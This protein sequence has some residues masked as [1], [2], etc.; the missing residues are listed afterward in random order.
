MRPIY[1]AENTAPLGS[2]RSKVKFQ[3]Y[4]VGACSPASNED[5]N[6]LSECRVAIQR[7][8]LQ[9]ELQGAGH[10]TTSGPNQRSYVLAKSGE[11]RS[12]RLA[13]GKRA[14]EGV[15]MVGEIRSETQRVVQVPIHGEGLPVVVVRK[16]KTATDH[17]VALIA[18]QVTKEA[19]PTTVWRP[20][21]GESW[22]EVVFVPV[23]HG[24]TTIGGPGAVH[25][26]WSRVRSA[27]SS[28]ASRE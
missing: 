22:L 18:E 26:N 14:I 25:A 8:G 28:A 2:V 12:Q 10:G 17:G 11:E 15:G 16:R 20:G 24:W 27:R 19:R 4:S 3:T 9:R 5:S 6:A 21:N 23:I 7:R 13:I 1:D